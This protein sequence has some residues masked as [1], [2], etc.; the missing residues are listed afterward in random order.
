MR[1][2][3]LLSAVIGL[4]LGTGAA[5]AQPAP[6]AMKPMAGSQSM[7][8]SAAP[9]AG[10][11]HSRR[12]RMAAKAMTP[13]GAAGDEAAPPTDAYRGGA[14]SPFSSRASNITAGDARSEMAPRLPDPEAAG[15]SPQAFLVA[16]QRALDRNQTGA[17]QEAL[18]RA[19]TR[20]LTRSTEATVAGQPDNN[21]MTLRIGEA[22]RA[23]AGRNPA[24]ARAAIAAALG[25]GG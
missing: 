2:P 7:E 24:A 13:A 3:L 6:E 22:R 4:G 23:L 5:I 12:G 11:P 19:E 16:A 14:G 17:A 21:T 15:N 1:N 25:N 10:A 9:I 20:V 8:Q 18:E